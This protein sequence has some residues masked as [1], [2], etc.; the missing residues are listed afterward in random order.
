MSEVCWLWAAIGHGRVEFVKMGIVCGREGVQ[1][2]ANGFQQLFLFEDLEANKS[3]EYH[4]DENHEPR[5][6]LEL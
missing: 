2:Y 4:D 5:G 1:G 3:I 6:K